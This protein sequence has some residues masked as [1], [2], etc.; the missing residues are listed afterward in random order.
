MD[1]KLYLKYIF[2]YTTQYY[3]LQLD[4]TKGLTSK[5]KLIGTIRSLELTRVLVRNFNLEY[6]KVFQT[7]FFKVP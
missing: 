6:K 4:V 3:T 1:C 7:N 2:I 5:P